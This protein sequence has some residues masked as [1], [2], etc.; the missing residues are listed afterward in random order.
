MKKH[1]KTFWL[2]S[3]Q[4]RFQ[5]NMMG[6]FNPWTESNLVRLLTQIF[7]GRESVIKIFD[8]RILS[9]LLIRDLRIFSLKGQA[10]K[11]VMVL[12]LP[13]LIYYLNSRAL[14]ERDRSK[15]NLIKI[16]PSVHRFGSRNKNLL[17]FPHMF[18]SLPKSKR[19][20]QRCLLN[21]KEHVWVFSSSDT[22]LNDKND[23]ISENPGPL[24]WESHSENDSNDI[25]WQIDSTFNSTQNE[26]WE[27][28]KL[29]EWIT[30]NESINKNGIKQLEEES[31]QTRE[32]E[33]SS[34]P[35]D[36]R[37]GE[38]EEKI[39]EESV[40][41]REFELS[42]RPE[43][44]RI[45]EIEEKIEEESVQTREF[46]LSSRPEDSRIGEIEEKIEE[47][48]VQTQKL[49]KR[50]GR[51]LFKLMNISSN[52][53]IEE[54]ER[55]EIEQEE[56]EQEEIEQEEIEQEEIEQEEIEQEESVRTKESHSFS[57]SEFWKGL[58][59]H[60]SIDESYISVST[61]NKPIEKFKV[62]K[63]QQDA[64][65]YFRGSERNRIVDLW[66]VKTYLKNSSANYD[67]SS[68]P[69]WN[70][71]RDLNQLNCIRFVNQSLPSISSSSCDQNKE[72][73]TLNDD[74]FLKKIVLK[75]TDQFTLSITKPNQAYD[76]EIA[77]DM[78]YHMNQFYEL[79]KNILLNQIFNYRDQLKENSF[80]VLLNIIDKEN[81]YVD[82]II[83]KN[84]GT[85]TSVR[86]ILNQYKIKV[87]KHLEKAFKRFYLWKNALIKYT[88]SKIFNEYSKYSLGSDPASDDLESET[89]LDE[90]PFSKVFQ[91]YYLEWKKVFHKYYLELTKVFHKYYL[92]LTKVFHKY[93]LELTKVFHK[94]YLEWKIGFN[95]F[96]LIKRFSQNFQ[97][98]IRTNW[99]RKDV[100]NNVTQDAINRHSS[101]WRKYQK[102]WFNHSILR[103]S[104]N[105]NRNLNISASSIQIEYFK[106]GL[107]RLVS[108][109]KQNNLKNRVFDPIELSTTHNFC[110]SGSTNKIFGIVFDDNDKD[111]RPIKKSSK[112]KSIPAFSQRSESLIDEGTLAP[113]GLNEKP[114]NQSIIDLFDNEKNYIELFD[115]T[116]ISTI[117]NDRDNWLNPLKL[118]N[119]NSLR[120][121]FCKANTFEFLDYLHHPRLNYKKRLASYMERIHIKNKNLIYGQLFNLVPIQ[122]NIFSWSIR[123]VHSEKETIS[124]IKSKVNIL[125]AKYLRDQALI[126]DLY[127]SSNLLTQLNSF[128]HGKIDISSIEEIYRTPL[129]SQQI[130]NFDKS[131]CHPFLNSSDSEENNPNQ[132]PKKG[133]S[134]NMGLIQNQSYQDD[135]LSEICFRM[136]KFAEKELSSSTESS[137][138][139]I[140]DKVIVDKNTLLKKE[141]RKILLFY[142]I[143][144]IDI[145][146]SKWDLFQ[147]YTLWFFTSTWWKYID[148]LFLTTFPEILISIS[149]QFICIL[150]D[151]RH[152]WNHN[153]NILWALS[154]QFWTLLKWEFRAKCMPKLNLLLSYWNLLDW[155][156]PITQTVF[157]GKDK[158]I[159]FDTWKYILNVREYDKFICIFI[160]FFFSVSC[161]VPLCL[162]PFYSNVEL[163]KDLEY[164][165]YFMKVGEIMHSFKMLR[166]YY[167]L[168]WYGCWLTFLDYINMERDYDDIGLSQILEI[169]YVKNWKWSSWPFKKC[170][171]LKSLL[172]R[173]LYEYGADDFFLKENRLFS[174]QE[175]ISQFE[176]KLTPPNGFFSQYF[177]KG[178]HPG[179]LYFRYLAE[180]IQLGQM[181]KIGLMNYE[182]DSSSLAERWVFR[183]F[184]QQITSLPTHPSLSDQVRFF[185]LY[186]VP[187]LSNR[188]LLIGPRETGRSY[189]SKSLAADSYLPLIR[190]SPKSFLKQE[191]L[192]LNYEAEY[193]SSAK[194][195]YL[196]HEEVLRSLGW[197][198]R[199]K[200]INENDSYEKK[201]KNFWH[202]R[203]EHLSPEYY[204]RRFCQFMFALKLAKLMYPCVIWIPSIHELND[205]F[206][207]TALLKELLG[208]TYHL[209]DYEEETNIKQ[210]IV[211]IASTHIPK[212]VDPVLIT[213]P[214][215]KRRFDTFINTKKFPAP[216]REKEFPLLLHS[217]GL[218][219]KKNWN[220]YDEFGLTTR[221]FTTLDLS[222][223]ANDIWRISI[224]RNTSAIGNDIIGEAMYRPSWAPNNYKFEF[225]D[226]YK[227]LPYKI[228]KAIIQN[229]LTYCR[230]FLNLRTD[231]QSRRAY[232]L[233]EWYLEPS[234]AG[235]AV[236]EL[237]IFYHILGCLAGS[238]AQDFWFLSESNRENWTPV[239]LFIAN[240]F[241]LASSLLQSLLEEF[242]SLITI[243]RGNSDKN[244]ITIAPQFKRDMMQKGLSS[245]VDKIVLSKE[246]KYSYVGELRTHIVCSP[247]TW[248]FSFIRSNRFD[249]IKDITIENPLL[250]YLHLFGGF[251]ERPTRLS[252]LF[253]KKFLSSYDPF[254]VYHDPSDVPQR[255]LAAFWEARSLY[256]RFKNMGIYQF[257]TEEYAKEYKP[258]DTPIICLARRFLWDPVSIRFKNKHPVFSRGELFVPQE[259]LKRIYL[260]YSS[261]RVIRGI[262]KTIKSIVRKKR[263]RKIALGIKIR[264]NNNDL[265]LNIKIEVKE[266][267]EAFK[268]FQEIGIRL[269]RVYPYRP[270]LIYDRWLREKTRDDKFRQ[271]LIEG[272]RGNIDLLS[273]ECFIYNTL[274]ESYEYLSN[275]FLTNRMLLKQILNTLLKTK[276]LSRND[277][278]CLLAEGLNKNKKD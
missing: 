123:P 163:L 147:T 235:T 49:R 89:A 233:H 161:I 229:K 57:E 238:V 64:F 162:I 190:I 142:N 101:S 164:E 167:N 65:Q 227:V 75:I 47:E 112:S 183:A 270:M 273:N 92:E 1:R 254:P 275:L 214:H 186:P 236:K 62:L 241:A 215:G 210:N 107:K 230:N 114:M 70:I 104:K 174:V 234:I 146:F 262:K 25:E 58:F 67:I 137:K 71:R 154:H 178:K 124:L 252:R 131:S 268:R 121:A 177:E 218:Y 130:V 10:I 212:K 61:T 56:I 173:V 53:R 26:Y 151:I 204:A 54:I 80:F 140:E 157:E 185:Q 228:G 181:N 192:L 63:R 94:Y 133:F 172:N 237:T 199:P 239:D 2:Y 259:L 263:V 4:S 168:S 247:R 221:G 87:D 19:R 278:H 128:V 5:V 135:L 125:L 187:S 55:E 261:A 100:L 153:L 266:H 12:T 226:I 246:L 171:K 72:Q 93:Y 201:P 102:E 106:K 81:Q 37:I 277:I 51:K 156:E 165:P 206:Y 267:I 88:L 189:L 108:I 33:L 188:I 208:D 110:W 103:T 194:K 22:N 32:F 207:L 41:T 40:Q 203:G 250:D 24:S 31:V 3:V 249:H 179:L 184:Q 219:L 205:H 78:D 152:N 191:R 85:E 120:A 7:S 9:T 38:I 196:E 86:F 195:S 44:S 91:K 136:K 197:S 216:H 274:S 243:C 169:W 132:Y 122:N 82:Q 76:N 84:D 17:L 264:D 244:H 144:Q 272:E 258:L 256:N 27:P 118:S 242:P 251:Q 139:I 8:F 155:K 39:E 116:G 127:K 45:G 111:S 74:F 269:R 223:L 166:F 271:F 225:S 99:I 138:N 200:D 209:G 83:I 66:K 15:Y 198:G 115:N 117:F 28:R 257:D 150:H 18:M 202:D 211:V 113:L 20:Y 231:L 175:R 11:A 145:L 176:S 220:C 143:S 96:Y 109:S 21:P 232:Y 30:T 14:V 68:D 35:E 77:L 260:T 43:D 42:S 48:S 276:W 73:F 222:K 224:S 217:K 16:F 23:I 13:L 149:D 265:P 248:R 60:L 34:R 97:D 148:N 69:G 105:I 141:K 79:N 213:P 90:Y 119:Q 193:T 253:W 52:F 95:Q 160:G 158:S 182:F 245:I 134:S 240:D 29:C 126:H 50:P 59:D 46:E 159:S 255:K 6:V 129:I 180:T 36:S 98:K 170:R